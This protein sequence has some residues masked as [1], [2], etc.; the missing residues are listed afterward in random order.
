MNEPTFSWPGEPFHESYEEFSTDRGQGVYADRI[1]VLPDGE[2]ILDLFINDEPA[3]LTPLDALALARRLVRFAA[4][5]GIPVK[6]DT[7][8]VKLDT[9]EKA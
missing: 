8:P 5:N 6:L 2:G 3:I 1:G 9:K 7:N 4:A